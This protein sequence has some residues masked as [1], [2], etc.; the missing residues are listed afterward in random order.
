MSNPSTAVR[1]RGAAKAIQKKLSDVGHA[2]ADRANTD[3]QDLL[4]NSLAYTIKRA[5]VRCDEALMRYLDAGISPARL[6]A[7]STVGTNPG[8]SQISLGSLLGIAAPSVVKVV[9]DLQKMGL[10]RR[11]K[12]NGRL[13]SLQLT[14]KGASNLQRYGVLVTKFESE[15][16]AALTAAERQQLLALLIKVAP[17]EP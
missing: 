8:I 4:A 5:Q 16:A 10:L 2:A 15:I 12:I 13:H 9:D 17:S 11:D 14:K 7:L 1:M 3:Q 6:A